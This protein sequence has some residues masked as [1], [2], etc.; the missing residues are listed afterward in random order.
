M[1]AKEKVYH[2]LCHCNRVYNN[3]N[4]LIWYENIALSTYVNDSIISEQGYFL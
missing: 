4:V 3:S 2:D 1:A